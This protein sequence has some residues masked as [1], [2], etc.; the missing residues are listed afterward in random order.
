MS[1]FEIADIKII[2][3]EHLSSEQIQ[4]LKSHQRHSVFGSLAWYKNIINFECITNHAVQSDFFLIFI[5]KK[6]DYIV[7]Y[8]AKINKK[9]ISLVSNFY[10]PRQEIFF[11]D[12]AI[13]ES[14][15]WELLIDSIK[16]YKFKWN[17]FYFSNINEN[18]LESIKKACINEKRMFFFAE[19]SKN[20]YVDFNTFDSYWA[21]RP[22]NIK[23]TISRKNKRLKQK[24]HTIIIK[25]KIS[26]DDIEDYWKV[27]RNSWKCSEPS[28]IFINWLMTEVFE[29]SEICIG[30]IYIENNPVAAQLWILNN[31]I[32]SI[33]KLAQDKSY[34]YYS[35]GSIL[36]YEM[37][38]YSANNQIKKVD[39]LLGNDSFKNLWM[40][41]SK[42]IYNLEIFNSNS[43]MG[44]LL[45]KF[46]S[47]K[48]FIKRTIVSIN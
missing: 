15:A 6:N 4:W 22:S 16:L 8:P 20:H 21:K 13:D 29:S 35:P 25:T 46:H 5:C 24:N 2:G 3:F 9:N 32:A 36:T 39:F 47:F 48:H 43:P 38:K 37:L 23:N 18:Q 10:T 14:T 31:S 7:A 27:Y 12:R 1:T 45:Q 40:D 44:M 33:F 26:Q 28:Q 17:R 34:D 30:I 11:D 41:S 42:P 19:N